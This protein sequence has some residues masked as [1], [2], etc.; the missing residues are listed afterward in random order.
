MIEIL[1]V[2]LAFSLTWLSMS[3]MGVKKFRRI[4]SFKSY[5]PTTYSMRVS[6]FTGFNTPQ[7]QDV[8]SEEKNV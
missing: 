2:L 3:I 7:P 1:G 8:V 4:G 6:R 5:L